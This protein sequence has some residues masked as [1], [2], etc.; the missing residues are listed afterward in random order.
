MIAL[1]LPGIVSPHCVYSVAFIHQDL[2]PQRKI[3][4]LKTMPDFFHNLVAQ[5]VAL[6][7]NTPVSSHF[8][9]QTDCALSLRACD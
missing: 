2:G 7:Y 9:A 3:R 1:V 5:C 8:I 4:K 6:K